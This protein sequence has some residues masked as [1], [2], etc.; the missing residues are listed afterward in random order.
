MN[1]Q[2]QTGSL[3]GNEITDLGS[4]GGVGICS[5]GI[6]STAYEDMNLKPENR[7]NQHEG[8]YA[9]AVAAEVLGRN[10]AREPKTA[11]IQTTLYFSD[12][13][14]CKK[15]ILY[16]FSFENHNTDIRKPYCAI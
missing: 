5:I 14:Y 12:F 16:T 7:L 8:V 11:I 9:P 15:P 2:S 1:V 4:E 13:M 6:T 3:S 10:S